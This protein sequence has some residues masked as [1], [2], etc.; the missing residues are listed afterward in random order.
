MDF[1]YHIDMKKVAICS[2]FPVVFEYPNF[3]FKIAS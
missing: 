1:D 3:Y 2:I